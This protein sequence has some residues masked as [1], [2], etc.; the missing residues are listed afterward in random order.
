MSGILSADVLAAVKLL[1]QIF[2]W[3]DISSLH[4]TSPF[5]GVAPPS[6]TFLKIEE[7]TRIWLGT[8]KSPISTFFMSV[9]G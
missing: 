5:S 4:A 3:N 2:N 7:K 9:G 1:K 6:W 8:I